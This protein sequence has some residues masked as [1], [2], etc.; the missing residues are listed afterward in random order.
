MRI[1]TNFS[2]F[3]PPS[4]HLALYCMRIRTS[5]NGKPIINKS[6]AASC[7][8]PQLIRM[9]FDTNQKW[10]GFVWP[11]A[12]ISNTNLIYI[13]VAAMQCLRFPVIKL[14]GIIAFWESFIFKRFHSGVSFRMFAV[15][16][17]D[18]PSCRREVKTQRNHCVFKRGAEAVKPQTYDR[19]PHDSF[20]KT[21]LLKG[22][23]FIIRCHGKSDTEVN[24]SRNHLR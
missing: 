7:D 11:K 15:S 12:A 22:N 23:G 24:T 17:A 19:P 21:F 1:G 14:Q 16:V 13:L 18:L 4:P 3:Q 6:S 20:M 9:T 5:V 2:E 8:Y 10:T